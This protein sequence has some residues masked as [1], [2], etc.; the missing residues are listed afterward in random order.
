M[1]AGSTPGTV[2]LN[3]N[4]RALGLQF[5][6]AGYT[7]S[8]N[9]LTLGAGGINASSLTTGTTTISST[10]SLQGG[11]LW[12]TGAGSTLTLSGS[13]IRNVGSTVDFST[14]GI[15]NGS[16]LSGVFSTI[17]NGWA[18]TG[19]TTWAIVNGG[20]VAGLTNYVLASTAGSTYAD[21]TNKDVDLNASVSN[22]SGGGQV[23]NSLRFNVSGSTL[24]WKGTT[25]VSGRNFWLRAGRYKYLRDQR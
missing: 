9:T 10:L 21:Y 13:L 22:T 2:N 16:A 25:T 24:N 11:Q 17:S 20:T 18:T 1:F 8:G 7:I 23:V 3:S 19:G 15:F 14:A 6:T 4:L 5:N 12:Q